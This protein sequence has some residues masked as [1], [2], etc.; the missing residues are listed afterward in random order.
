MFTSTLNFTKD[1]RTLNWK[2]FVR[3]SLPN[4]GANMDPIRIRPPQISHIVHVISYTYLLY[5]ESHDSLLSFPPCYQYMFQKILRSISPSY[6]NSLLTDCRRYIC[7]Q[8]HM[9]II[10]RNSPWS[11]S[12]NAP[13]LTWMFFVGGS[14]D[15]YLQ[16]NK[17]IAIENHPKKGDFPWLC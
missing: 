14:M 1:C 13:Q 16:V 11:T 8:V 6:S 15:P 12:P 2:A 5:V 9:I 4:H 17:L 3:G 10:I 7:K